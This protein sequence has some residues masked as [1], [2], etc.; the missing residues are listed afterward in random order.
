MPHGTA[1]AHYVDPVRLRLVIQDKVGR[2]FV[3]GF[4]V[5]LP[6]ETNIDDAGPQRSVLQCQQRHRLRHGSR[7]CPSAFEVDPGQPARDY[8]VESDPA[9]TNRG[10]LGEILEAPA[11]GCQCPRARNESEAATWRRG[12]DTKTSGALANERHCAISPQGWAREGLEEFALDT[13]GDWGARAGDHLQR[14]AH[15]CRK[16]ARPHAVRPEVKAV[17]AAPPQALHCM[18]RCLS[19]DRRTAC[20]AAMGAKENHNTI[21]VDAGCEEAEERQAP[22]AWDHV[23]GLDQRAR[24]SSNSGSQV[25]L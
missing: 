3:G 24:L 1:T 14:H 19:S 13:A 11:C 9:T 15:A 7:H 12:V 18:S 10:W 8:S 22:R 17:G 21:T 20:S 16:Y 2:N 6:A 5:C 4:V 23:A 25:H